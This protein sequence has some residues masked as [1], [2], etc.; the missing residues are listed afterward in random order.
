MPQPKESSAPNDTVVSA[1]HS[2]PLYAAVPTDRKAS[3]VPLMRLLL[4]Y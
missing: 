4:C 1:G 2:G 3:A